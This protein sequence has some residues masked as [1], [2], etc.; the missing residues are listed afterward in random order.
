MRST[1]LSPKNS[2]F[3]HPM[4]QGSDA[5]TVRPA[6]CVNNR[7]ERTRTQQL[8]GT[9]FDVSR[10][11]KNKRCTRLVLHMLRVMVYQNPISRPPATRFDTY[12]I[13][14]LVWVLA[15]RQHCSGSWRSCSLR[16][17]RQYLDQSLQP[18]SFGMSKFTGN[19]V[20]T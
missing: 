18:I 4:L 10:S 16:N 17:G 9:C 3:E 11:Y 12:T 8:T 1:H 7:S 19:S 15:L 6:T 5:P 13:D 14:R 20:R 2:P